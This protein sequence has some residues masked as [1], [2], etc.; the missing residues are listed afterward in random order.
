MPPPSGRDVVVGQDAT[1]PAVPPAEEI[2]EAAE[3]ILRRP[4]FREPPK[5]LY[6]RLQELL[7]EWLGDAFGALVGD[8]PPALL[9]WA[10]LVGA[11]GVAAYLAFRGLQLDRRRKGLQGREEAVM[12]RRRPPSDWEAEAA[13][14]EVR[15]EWRAALRCR[16]RALIARLAGQGV[17]DEVAGRTAGEYRAV[18]DQAAPAV[19]RDFAGATD[20]FERA[21]YGNAPTGQEEAGTFRDLSDRVL[22]E[23]DR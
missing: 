22:A 11:L 15:G 4:E 21:W 13:A 14:H 12:E 18:V 3:E 9:A 23:V 10:V 1:P 20:L 5:S 7:A 6:Q 2:R 17:V 19:A 16:Y 8:G